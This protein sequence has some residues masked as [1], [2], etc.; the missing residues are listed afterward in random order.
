MSC[1]SLEILFLKI[2]EQ[3]PEYLM[4]VLKKQIISPGENQVFLTNPAEKSFKI[5]FVTFK[6]KTYG[7]NWWLS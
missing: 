4:S 7:T 3:F 2:Q 5:K 6:F 1:F